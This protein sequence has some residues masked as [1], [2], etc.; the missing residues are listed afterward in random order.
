MFKTIDRPAN[1]EMRAVIMFLNAR[2]VRPCEMYRQIS[3]S[4]SGPSSIR[5]PFVFSSR[6][7]SCRPQFASDD[8]IKANVQNWFRSQAVEFYE[9]GMLQLVI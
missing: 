1:F 8:E 9:A 7:I 3:E 5:L 2:N 6:E 4:Q